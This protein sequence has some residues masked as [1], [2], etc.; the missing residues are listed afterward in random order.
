MGY[1]FYLLSE[2]QRNDLLKRFPPRYPSVSAHHVTIG[3]YAEAPDILPHAKNISLIGIADDGIGIQALIASVDGQRLR[4]FDNNPYHIT[5]SFD[6]EKT[7]P[8]DFDINPDKEKRIAQPY[9]PVHSNRLIAMN[10]WNSYFDEPINLGPAD[11]LF[12]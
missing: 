7:A 5:W 11:A 2:Q 12:E 8:A 1:L 9:A 10:R 3:I 4:S 6:P